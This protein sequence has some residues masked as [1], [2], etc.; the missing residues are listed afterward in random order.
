MTDNK[1]VSVSDCCVIPNISNCTLEFIN[2]GAS[3]LIHI[4]CWK[5][6]LISLERSASWKKSLNQF[7]LSKNKAWLSSNSPEIRNVSISS[8]ACAAFQKV[9]SQRHSSSNQPFVMLQSGSSLSSPCSCFFPNM[10][11]VQQSVS[12]CGRLQTES[13]KGWNNYF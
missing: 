10:W 3:H 5:H 13:W 8:S 7:F 9:C 11:T 4:S 2:R 6:H 1:R 12:I